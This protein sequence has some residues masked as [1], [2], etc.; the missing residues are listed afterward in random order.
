M[1]DDDSPESAT[2]EARLVGES[3]APALEPLPM[4]FCP[5]CKEAFEG[6]DECPDHDLKLVKFDELPDARRRLADEELLAPLDLRYGRGVVLAG[7]LALFVGF[8]LPLVTTTVAG[9]AHTVAA[10]GFA[11]YRFSPLWAIPMA[12]G[13]AASVV[14]RCRTRRSLRRMRLAVPVLGLV[15]GTPTVY[16]ISFFHRGAAAAGTSLQVA[17]DVT[18]REGFYLI[19]L[20]AVA[21]LVGGFRLGSSSVDQ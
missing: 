10:L 20:G 21:F 18:L 5:F 8:C 9:D 19:A 17:A 11:T 13:A 16:A 15:A 14:L 3:A 12:A 6:V 2:E 7:T 4:R 1:A